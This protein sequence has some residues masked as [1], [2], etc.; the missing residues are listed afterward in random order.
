MSNGSFESPEDHLAAFVELQ[1]L[2]NELGFLRGNPSAS[3][4]PE[5]DSFVCASLKPLPK[6]NS[7]AIAVPEPD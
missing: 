2:G 4:E 5:E 3:D 6:L 7:G 1:D